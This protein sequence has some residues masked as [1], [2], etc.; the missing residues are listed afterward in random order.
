MPCRSLGT[1]FHY[2]TSTL[3][4]IAEAER[5]EASVA[6][7]AHW[8]SKWKLRGRAGWYRDCAKSQS[9]HEHRVFDWT[10]GTAICS[11]G[12]VKEAVEISDELLMSRGH[13]DIAT[14]LPETFYVICQEVDEE[15]DRMVCICNICGSVEEVPRQDL[16][17]EGDVPVELFLLLRDSHVC[18]TERQTES[19]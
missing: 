18:T 3:H 10:N 13:I 2:S 11:C 6:G 4:L 8:M 7:D 12:L 9:H 17:D 16:S 19:S 14:E 15:T 1:E 5:L